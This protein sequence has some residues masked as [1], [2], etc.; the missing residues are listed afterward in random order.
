MT[1]KTS[2]CLL[3][4]SVQLA[5][6]VI[7]QQSLA[8]LTAE[9]TTTL[10]RKAAR[11]AVIP[12]VL[13][14]GLADSASVV[15]RAVLGRTAQWFSHCRL[16]AL[17]APSVKAGGTLVSPAGLL[18]IDSVDAIDEAQVDEEAARSGYRLSPRGRQV[19]ND[20]KAS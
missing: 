12:G 17:E 7:T 9:H 2:G 10:H 13:E 18:A 6:K 3:L 4:E 16:S 1:K 19:L 20:H 15:Q 8:N 11:P 14:R 5:S